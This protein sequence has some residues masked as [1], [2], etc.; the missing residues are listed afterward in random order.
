MP[1]RVLPS[2][3]V[4][5][6]ATIGEGTTI[7]HLAQVREDA[8]IGANCIVGRGAYVDTGVEVGD[9]TKIQNHA[10]VYA[11]ARLGEGVFV[12]PAVVLTNDVYPRSIDPDGHLKRG[13]DWDAGGVVVE[14]G[15][16]LG[17]RSVIV[18]GVTIG[19][20]A[21]VGAGAVVTKD[22][23]AHA[24]VVGV[25]ARRVGWV[26]TAGVPLQRDGDAWVCPATGDRY[27]EHDHVLTPVTETQ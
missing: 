17:A 4:D 1:P 24:L 13:D 10:L 15:A 12:G 18:A 27:L 23:P 25:P 16:A 5:E 3:D 22:V 19:A 6:R 21:L 14:R 26:G 11:P 9:N 2:A 7:W 20:W 8:V